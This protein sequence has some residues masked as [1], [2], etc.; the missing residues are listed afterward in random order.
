MSMKSYLAEFIGTFFLLFLGTG[1]ITVNHVTNNSIGHMG[2]SFAFG[3]VI[4][5][6]IYACG[7]VSGAH[8]NPAVTIAFAV[9]RKFETKKIIPYFISQLLG[10]VAGCAL[11]SFLFGAASYKGL[12]LPSLEAQDGSGLVTTSLVAE[13]V[14]TFC[15]MYVIM[16]VAT[17]SRAESGFAGLAIGMTIF[18]G[19]LV[20]G[21]ISGG[22][23]NP[24]RSIAPA[25]IAGNLQHLWIYL[26]API[27]GAVA[28]GL[29]YN[30]LNEERRLV[31]AEEN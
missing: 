25:I 14:M 18:V 9:C 6:M 8:F 27:I 24:A 23:F 11:V 29:T 20:T 21:P 19:A 1:A 28:G 31:F 2:I 22:S 16:S 5:I 15:L 7:H 26:V 13:L 17:D 10:A 4:L 12:T 30:L 3:F